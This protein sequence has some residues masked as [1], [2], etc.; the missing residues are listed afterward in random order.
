LVFTVS[1]PVL[2]MIDH[3]GPCVATVIKLQCSE[4]YM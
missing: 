1:I 3:T 2:S 4:I